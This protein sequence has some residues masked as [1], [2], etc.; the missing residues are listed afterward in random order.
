[1]VFAT[2]GTPNLFH[3]AHQGRYLHVGST[4]LQC[5]SDW[6]TV[7]MRVGK[8]HTTVLPQAE[9]SLGLP[10]DCATGVAEDRKLGVGEDPRGSLRP[11]SPT[12]G[13]SSTEGSR[14]QSG[15]VASR[16][17]RSHG[18]AAIAARSDRTATTESLHPKRYG[19]S[20]QSSYLETEEPRCRI[21]LL[22]T[23]LNNTFDSI[24]R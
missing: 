13:V 8:G 3:I 24:L 22:A 7:H 11:F 18:F 9:G 6:Y 5:V 19:I 1:M 14:V 21:F 12:E 16:D 4:S 10:A 15:L 20:L 2:E 23:T 17:F